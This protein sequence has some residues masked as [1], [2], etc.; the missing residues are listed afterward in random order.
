MFQH[1][2]IGLNQTYH[3]FSTLLLSVLYW[4]WFLVLEYIIPGYTLTGFSNYFEY[5]LAILLGLQVSFL[6]RNDRDIFSINRGILE[7]HRFVRPHILIAT[8]ITCLFLVLT[9]DDAISRAFLFTYIPMAY[10]VMVLFTRYGAFPLLKSMQRR[11]HQKLLLIGMPGDLAKVES[12][13]EKARFFGLDPVGMVTEAPAEEL[14][15]DLPKLGEPHEVLRVLESSEIDSVFILSSPR[16]RRVL[17]EWM[18]SAER[19]GCRLSMVNDLDVFL[20][21]RLSY[22]RCDNLDLIELREEPLQSPINRMLKRAFDVM[23]SLP[24][25]MLVLPPLMLLVWI[26]QRLQAPGPLFFR[27]IRSGI[28]NESFTILKF[29]TMY[30]EKFDSARQASREDPRVFPAAKWLRRFSLDEF[31]QFFNV[32]TG[33]MSIVGPRPHMVQHDEVFARIMSNYAIRG[34]VKP[35]LSGLAQIRG[36]RGETATTED[37]VRRV[38]ADLEYIESWS[39]MLDVRIVWQTLLQMIRPPDG[40]R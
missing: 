28:D 4:V 37:V 19:H 13:L 21:R 39:I 40:A 6:S 22:F 26:L 29:R 25:A 11:E 1:R 18:R 8:A 32:L 10:V 17:G 34:F 23:V 36:F 33:Q 31:P 20:Q 38:E 12:L 30:D 35:G 27:Q 2:E 9:K 3:V 16:D 5:F 7:S 24:V 15:S 14:P